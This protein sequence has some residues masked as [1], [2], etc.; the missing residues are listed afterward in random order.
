MRKFYQNKLWRDKAV[1]WLLEQGS[2]LHWRVLNDNEM[3]HELK[4]KLI[5]EAHEVHAAKTKEEL[6]LELADILEVVETIAHHHDLNMNEI[7]H[8]QHE[9]RLKRGGFMGRK[10]VSLAE[11][12][13]G[14]EAERYCLENPQKYPELQ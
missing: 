1:D 4:R 2:I 5:E 10:F 9:K 3:N 6:C 7:R 14:S 11:H 8:L 12:P 13:A